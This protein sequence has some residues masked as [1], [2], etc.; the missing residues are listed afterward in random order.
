[1]SDAEHLFMFL[2]TICMSFGEECLFRFFSHDLIGLFVFLILIGLS[3]LDIWEINSLSVV[4]FA[5]VFFPF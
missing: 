2:F 5:S 1:M 3:G 4:S